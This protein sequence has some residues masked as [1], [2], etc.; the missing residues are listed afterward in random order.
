MMGRHNHLAHYA[1]HYSTAAGTKLTGYE[2]YYKKLGSAKHIVGPMVEQSELAWRILCRRYNA[3]L[4]YTPMFH[5][6]L[7][8][9]PI[10]GYKYRSDQWST[11]AQD[12]PLIVQFCGNDPDTLLKAAKMVQD[13]CDAIDLNLGCPQYI[14]KKGR[15]G[16][17][18]QDDWDLIHK[19][20]STLDKHLNVPVTAKIRVFSSETKTVNYAKM[21]VEAGAQLL[22]VHGRLREQKGHHTG[23]ADWSKIKAVKKHC[24]N[25]P[26][27]A[28]G[29]ILYYD[30]VQHCLDRTGADG[31]MSAENNLYNPAI[32]TNSE[33][34]PLTFEIALEY[35]DICN[36]QA[37]TRPEIVKAHL[38]KLFHASLPVH[39]D[40]RNRLAVSNSVQEMEKIT[41]ELKDRLQKEMSLSKDVVDVNPETGIRTYAAWRCQVIMT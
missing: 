40:L 24:S 37:L 35:L 5:S 3:H 9:D 26:V 1:R 29:N 16:S 27:I 33:M 30:D 41:L 32:F 39:T 31:V 18:L 21:L 11:N 20:I 7:F 4:C 23:V 34:P 12:R 19:L 22:T 6:K 10:H 17:F 25:V 36:K 13:Q 14:A 28:N 38:F 15:Y 8:S 2:F